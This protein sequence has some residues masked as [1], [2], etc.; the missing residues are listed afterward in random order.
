[1]KLNAATNRGT[2]IS[3]GLQETGNF[4][5]RQNA[6]MFNA[7]T[8]N[9]YSD[10][11]RAIIRELSCNA[12]DAHT[13]VGQTKPFRVVLPSSTDPMLVVRDYGPGLSHDDIMNLYTTFFDST[14]DQENDSVGAFG[15][16]SKSPFS[17][18]D[19]FTVT[20]YYAGYKRVY[21]AVRNDE[22]MPTISRIMEVE[23]TEDDEQAGLEVTVPISPNDFHR[24]SKAAQSTLKY[25]PDNSFKL[26]GGM[27]IVK[28]EYLM[29]TPRWALLK[30]DW[31][32]LKSRAIMGP[33]AYDIDFEAA[34]LPEDMRGG[35]EFR[36]KLGEVDI[37]PSR[38]SLSMDKHTISVLN[39]VFDQFIREIRQTVE[40]DI[41]KANSLWEA[42]NLFVQAKQLAKGPAAK[43][44]PTFCFYKAQGVNGHIDVD[45]VQSFPPNTAMRHVNRNAL[46]RRAS[47]L[48]PAL[49]SIRI[50]VG[51]TD[52]VVCDLWAERHP[53]IWARLRENRNQIK[54]GHNVR[55]ILIEG[56]DEASIQKALAAIGSPENYHRLSN[57]AP[58]ATPT[59]TGGGGRA[60][61]S[62][63]IP[64]FHKYAPV[65]EE[66]WCKRKSDWRVIEESEAHL[67]ID[68]R[69]VPLLG[70]DIDYAIMPDADELI[71]NPWARL[72]TLYGFPKRARKEFD[73]TEYVR[74]DEYMQ[75]KWEQIVED[76][77]DEYASAL[78]YIQLLGQLPNTKMIKM[79]IVNNKVT[80]ATAYNAFASKILAAKQEYDRL[81]I[82]E[83]EGFRQAYE[84]PTVFKTTKNT[85]EHRD[86]LND[87]FD[88]MQKEIPCTWEVIKKTTDIY[89]NVSIS[90]HPE[91]VTKLIKMEANK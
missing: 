54:T 10:K 39:K 36:F 1:M 20:S 89:N 52:I 84:L 28:D 73:M 64:T 78:A 75:E 72:T 34:G 5:I 85:K 63:G 13:M 42:N 8:S 21:A 79:F 27:P 31:H 26:I 83:V 44:F 9:I 23:L 59:L 65:R 4:N 24:F 25:F 77:W 56:P 15:L 86:E 7:L 22:G 38:E 40:K 80:G 69:Y 55:V 51:R 91:L 70:S 58:P 41:L 3:E 61:S 71:K 33:V 29:E 57:M 49:N 14:K 60:G 66:S 17:Y 48:T 16:G 32:V 35:L 30:T 2:V 11:P 43:L 90:N 81:G 12:L 68:G 37:S 74:L 45:T 82:K 62:R 88:A 18:T 67:H 6:K 46:E 50:D 76:E 53:R 87:M 47:Q 19:A